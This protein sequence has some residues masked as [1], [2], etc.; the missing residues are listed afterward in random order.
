MFGIHQHIEM[1]SPKARDVRGARTHGGHDVHADA[2]F[3]QQA[4]QFGDIVAVT[5]AQGGRADQVGGDLFGARTGLGQMPDNLQEGLIRAKTLFALIR[6][7]I[8]RDHRQ[9][10]VHG[11]SQTGRIVLN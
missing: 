9:A 1:G 8:K 6:W 10:Q 7:Q 2:H 3:T 11:T 4:G 5:K